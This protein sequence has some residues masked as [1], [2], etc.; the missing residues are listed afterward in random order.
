MNSHPSNN[1]TA[2]ILMC[3]SN[4]INYSSKISKYL[5]ATYSHTTKIVKELEKKGLTKIE[6]NGRQ[7]IIHLTEK[8]QEI[9]ELLIK[10]NELWNN[11]TKNTV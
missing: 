11:E 2:K 3:I 1:M 7:T 4:R 5:N 6:K 10:V 9:K 8:G